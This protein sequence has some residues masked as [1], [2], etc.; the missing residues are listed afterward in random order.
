MAILP[1]LTYPDPRL[2][3]IATPIVVVD[4]EIRTFAKNIAETMYASK[5]IGLAAT[6]VNVHQQL[7]VIDVSPNQEQLQTFINPRIIARQG[8]IEFEEGCLS[9]P[10][11]LVKVVRASEITVEALDLDGKK[12]SK[13]VEG[14]EAVCL[15]HEID[16][17]K[18]IVFVD[19]LS[20]LKRE[21][22]GKKLVKMQKSGL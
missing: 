1:I 7:I 17:L 15:Q 8:K 12:I 3:K 13:S 14:L 21:R 6:Q 9:V 5:G 22:I 4:D 11:T 16:H 19:Y 10:E 2:K 18:G 20:R